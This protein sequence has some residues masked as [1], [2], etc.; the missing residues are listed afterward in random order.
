MG[1]LSLFWYGT[2]VKFDLAMAVLGI[3]S[4]PT[5]LSKDYPFLVTDELNKKLYNREIKLDS[6][7]KSTAS[8]LMA[9]YRFLLCKADITR[10]H[11]KRQK[12]PDESILAK[13]KEIDIGIKDTLDKM[14]DLHG[15]S[16]IELFI[17]NPP[18]PQSSNNVNISQNVVDKQ[19]NC[20]ITD[21]SDINISK[22]SQVNVMKCKNP[23]IISNNVNISVSL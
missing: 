19:N 16:G 1:G 5:E 21:T 23:D 7:D 4:L 6:L 15:V 13:I 20:M 11:L 3:K 9:Y 8:D 10:R 17:E 22:N 18:S 14:T 12:E 2:S